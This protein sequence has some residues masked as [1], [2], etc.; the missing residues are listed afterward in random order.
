MET[1]VERESHEAKVD[2]VFQ[3]SWSGRERDCFFHN[4]DGATDLFPNAAWAVGLDF[5]DDGRSAIAAD[6]DGDGDLDLALLSLQGL[7]LVLNSSPPRGWARVRLKATGTHA[8]ALGAHVT[9]QAGGTTQQDIVRVTD[10]FQSQ[11]PLDLHFGLGDAA[12]I[13]RLTVRWPSGKVEEHSDLPARRLISIVEGD[14][15]AVVSE[16]PRWPAGAGT[17]A[18]APP[19]VA[20]PGP[21]AALLDRRGVRLNATGKTAEALELFRRAL[22]LDPDRALTHYHLGLSFSANGDPGR[23]L[24]HMRRA[25][26]LDAGYWSSRY[27]LG[28]FLYNAGRA[29]EAVEHYTEA[30]RLRP[31]DVELLCA[32]GDAAGASSRG[33]IADDAFQRAVRM[34]PHDA[35]VHG[36]RGRFLYS[37]GQISAARATFLHALTLDP[38]ESISRA[39]LREIEQKEREAR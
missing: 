33:S 31:D 4:T 39:F 12:R 15:A 21:S 11:V 8:A 34:A 5:D 36:R 26:E 14:T 2:P 13:D 10:G 37:I 3:G 32:L 9:V 19:A 22:A 28:V 23:G 27:N 18:P 17:A 29:G 1:K 20:P 38:N 25:V 6:V 30:V 24:V 16:L 35:S 7:R